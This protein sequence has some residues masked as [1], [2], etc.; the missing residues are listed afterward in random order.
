MFKHTSDFLRAIFTLGFNPEPYS[1]GAFRQMDSLNRNILDRQMGRASQDHLGAPQSSLYTQQ[2]FLYIP[3]H[4]PS[5]SF[6]LSPYSSQPSAHSVSPLLNPIHPYLPPFIQ[7]LTCTPPGHWPGSC[8]CCAQLPQCRFQPLL[9]RIAHLSGSKPGHAGC[10]PLQSWA[11]E[12]LCLNP[13]TAL[14]DMG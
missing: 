5:T 8:F 4:G 3:T 6:S 11:P 12:T 10:S 13:S 1:L 9:T 7:A 2:R 14:A